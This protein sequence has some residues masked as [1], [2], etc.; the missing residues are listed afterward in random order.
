M[1]VKPHGGTLINRILSEK[2]REAILS[3]Q[4]K[5]FNLEIDEE[6][7][8][9]VQNIA[10]G[11][12]SPLQGFM[13]QDD[14]RE[15]VQRNRLASGHAWTL[16]IV[17]SVG[18]ESTK[19]FAKNDTIILKTR[20][21]A[22]ASMQVEDIYTWNF[23]EYA[24][25]VYGTTDE[26]HPGVQQLKTSGEYFVG[27]SVNFL[28]NTISNFPA[29][30]LTPR[31]TRVLF[32]EKKWDTV[33]GF[34][35]RNVSHLGHEYVQKSAQ[36]IVDGLFINPVIGKKKTGDFT[37]QV[38]L[39]SYKALIDEYYV[40]ERTVMSIL[41][42]EMRYAGPK[43]AVFHAIVRKNF[44]CSHFIVGRDHAGVGNYY[45][46][47]AAQKIFEFF[48][49]LGITP[50]FFMSFFFCKKCNSIANDKTC[51]HPQSDH[52]DFAGKIIREKLVDH[53]TPPESMMRKE[54]AEEIL[55]H[56]NPFVE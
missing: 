56:E 54:V 34:Q 2:E 41:Q 55:K 35:T 28:G 44:G 10:S 17:L 46:P 19:Q 13:T 52:I 6:K 4:D 49:D 14:F 3:Y 7:A 37:D 40:K 26:K 36:S 24:K 30:Y 16:P 47:F 23:E 45:H 32:K 11:V 15:V 31:E 25:N 50:I 9:E 27:G 51:P 29:Y 18:K 12:F 38:I 8:I 20:E 48:P 43:E 42:T 33:V 39:D 53:Q 21:G 22:I 1:I 5:F